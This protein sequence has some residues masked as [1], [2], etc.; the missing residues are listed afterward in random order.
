MSPFSPHG[1]QKS[2]TLSSKQT[3]NINSTHEAD[4][5]P[6]T[7]CSSAMVGVWCPAR[8]SLAHIVA[9]SNNRI[10]VNRLLAR[11][12]LVLVSAMLS[13]TIARSYTCSLIC[14]IA[15]PLAHTLDRS[16]IYLL[17]Y[18]LARSNQAREKRNN[19]VE[20]GSENADDLAKKTRK[21][22]GCTFKRKA[23]TRRQFLCAGDQK[24]FC[25]H[26]KLGKVL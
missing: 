3:K 4:L 8:I 5:N 11:A 17:I 26:G 9:R 24:R 25:A 22:D 7:S 19:M 20:G 10:L 13:Q 12:L 2:C 1:L 18:L 14:S 6:T 16:L 23:C 15:H 21:T